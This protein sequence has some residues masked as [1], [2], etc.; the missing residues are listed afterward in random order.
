MQGGWTVRGL[1]P[2]RREQAMLKDMEP[3][4]MIP[5][6]DLEKTRKFYEDVLGFVPRSRTPAASLTGADTAG[7]TSTPRSSP[8]PRSTP[9]SAGIRMTSRRP[10][11][12][13]PRRA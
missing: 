13:S 11:R 1:G 9:S 3:A 6:K 10:L 7:S 12:S 5:V 2:E 4:T 8:G